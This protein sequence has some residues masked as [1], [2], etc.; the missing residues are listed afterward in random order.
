MCAECHAV[1]RQGQRSSNSQAPSFVAVNKKDGTVGSVDV[2]EGK[3][4]GDGKLATESMMAWVDPRAEWMQMFN[5]AWS[6]D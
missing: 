3:K 6:D 4:V 1:G 2:A 5:E